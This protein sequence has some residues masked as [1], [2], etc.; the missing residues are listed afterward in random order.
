[1]AT[2]GERQGEPNYDIRLF[3]KYKKQAINNN[4]EHL[5]W[6]HSITHDIPNESRLNIELFWVVHRTL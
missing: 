1:M 4:T 5:Q 3:I 2:Y 6:G